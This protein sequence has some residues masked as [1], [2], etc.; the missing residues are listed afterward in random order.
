MKLSNLVQLLSLRMLNRQ[1]SG[2]VFILRLIF[3]LKVSDFSFNIIILPE[4]LNL[5]QVF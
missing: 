2:A 1:L 4:L 3:G 5:V